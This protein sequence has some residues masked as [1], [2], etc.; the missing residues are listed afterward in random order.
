MKRILSYILVFVTVFCLTA[1]GEKAEEGPSDNNEKE[2]PINPDLV[3]AF[4]EEWVAEEKDT[5]EEIV[6]GLEDCYTKYQ[7]EK[8]LYQFITNVE[9]TVDPY[10]EYMQEEIRS[11]LDATNDAQKKA[12]LTNLLLGT[13]LTLP[14]DLM[15]YKFSVDTGTEPDITKQEAEAA[16][17]EYI[18]TISEYFC[19]KPIVEVS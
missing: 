15:M 16:V 5:I 10:L 1:C 14:F 3:A 13:N 19:A 4:G 2:T 9:N 7:K 11:V 6:S 12:E 8:D 17:I 18:N